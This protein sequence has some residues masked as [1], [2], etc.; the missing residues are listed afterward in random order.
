MKVA[1]PLSVSVT[2]Y[3][4]TTLTLAATVSVAPDDTVKLP[5]KTYRRLAVEAVPM[6][7]NASVW[8][9]VRVPARMS[10]SWNFATFCWAARQICTSVADRNRFALKLLPTKSPA[11]RMLPLSR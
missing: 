4:I 7:F 3:G 10:M 1:V 2:L 6:A 9:L 11:L 5:E 8:P